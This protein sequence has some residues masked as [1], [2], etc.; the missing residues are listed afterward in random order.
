M[1]AIS[2]IWTTFT[3]ISE[4]SSIGKWSGG[5]GELI[6]PKKNF[7]KIFEIAHAISDF[8]IAHACYFK[9]I[10]NS[11]CYFK[12]FQNFFF[13]L[14]NSPEPPDHLPMLEASEIV[15]KVVQIYDQMLKICCF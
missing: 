4:A 10:W 2:T 9:K 1:H 5:S 11:M 3:T 8:E 15:V 13:G 6:K 7:L 12:N 14:I